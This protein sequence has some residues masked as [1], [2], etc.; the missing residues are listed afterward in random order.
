MLMR[1]KTSKEVSNYAL[2]NSIADSLYTDL[3]DSFE[4][5][6]NLMDVFAGVCRELTF[7]VMKDFLYSV[8]AGTD[9]GYK[10]FSNKDARV[11]VRDILNAEALLSGDFV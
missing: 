11:S 7:F 5:T 9:T 2:F 3:I 8:F 6:D 1:E 10:H 4:E